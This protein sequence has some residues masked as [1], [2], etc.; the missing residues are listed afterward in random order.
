MK[1][2]LKT[3]VQVA[4]GLMALMG[5]PSLS[6]V[7]SAVAPPKTATVQP[8]SSENSGTAK[9]SEKPN[10]VK[11]NDPTS[12]K[13]K[14]QS[15]PEQST[16]GQKQAAP[17]QDLK[18]AAPV[19]KA[20]DGAEKVEQK[21]KS[22]AKTVAKTAE[23]ADAAD[24][25]EGQASQDKP[26]D[27][28]ASS[29]SLSNE[30]LPEG[31]VPQL[32]QTLKIAFSK[33]VSEDLSDEGKKSVDRALKT[34]CQNLGKAMLIGKGP[35]NMGA[36]SGVFCTYAGKKVAGN[37]KP[38][39][40]VLEIATKEDADIWTLKSPKGAVVASLSVNASDYLYQMLADLE[41]IDLL[42]V[43]FLDSMPASGYAVL[44][45]DGKLQ[46]IQGR[47]PYASKAGTR[48]FGLVGP[49]NDEVLFISALGKDEVSVPY[50]VGSVTLEKPFKDQPVKTPPKG[51]LQAAA[52]KWKVNVSIP[53]AAKGQ[54]GAWMQSKAGRGTLASKAKLEIVTATKSLIEAGENGT[55]QDYIDGVTKD[56]L[57]GQ[58]AGGYVGVRYGKQLFRNDKLLAKTTFLGVVG[59]VRAGFLEGFRFYYDKLP[60]AKE[61]Q[62]GFD[63][64]I[65]WSR[66]IVGRSFGMNLGS[67]IDRLEITPKLG[68]WNFDSTMELTRNTD[69]DVTSVGTFSLTRAFSFAL[70]AGAEWYSPAYALR[71]WYGFDGAAAISK[72]GSKRVTSN[73]MGIE[74]IWKAGP[75]FGMFGHKFGT[76]LMAFYTYESINL[77]DTS[78]P[79]TLA[80]ESAITGVGFSSGYL[81]LGLA[82]SW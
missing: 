74:T 5:T 70:E 14:A 36:F 13:V 69:G 40:Y 66:I 52:L 29:G 71:L 62:N 64:S 44:P 76:A 21:P 42:A 20:V 8:K 80:D 63:T 53:A 31:V 58:F 1:V 50:S 48:K 19:A 32:P 59:E 57:M 47:A 38:N 73:R 81:G 49:I 28:K 23:P 65:E 55:L 68:V 17:S 37:E 46:S 45:K 54:T 79:D 35:W 2:N 82:L 33:P 25:Y 16:E 43:Y 9:P 41:Y 15:K 7:K 67:F 60:K 4:A 51:K 12:E 30:K 61:S 77:T 27:K 6:Q 26:V 24:E 39:P 22:G 72:V 34:A 10:A 11:A 18:A 3:I 75:R 78:D 56:S